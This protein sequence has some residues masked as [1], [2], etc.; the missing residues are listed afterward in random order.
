MDLEQVRGWA[1][2]AGA[3]AMRYYNAVEVRRKLDR[4]PVTAAD[5]EIEALL[6]AR[7][8]AAYPTHGVLGEEQ[9]LHAIDAEYVWVIDPI[10]GTGSF[11]DG[12][13]LWGISI[14]LLHRARP[15]LGSFYMPA[16]DEWYE[17]DRS[18]PALFNGTP[19]TVKRDDLLDSEA[20]LAVPSNMHR[21]Y[22]I[23][24]PGKVRSIGSTAAAICY[25]AR[26]SAAGALVGWPKLWDIAAGLVLLERAGGAA[27]L[28]RSQQPLDIRT[29]LRGEYPAEP[30]IV[31]SPEALELMAERIQVL[32]PDVQ[33]D[34]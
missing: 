8:A 3:I 13:P 21:R 33:N 11:V 32:R 23:D 15:V 24:Y 34:R 17:A 28:L 1:R 25:V 18:G 7:I 29:M 12:L 10:D 14:G 19:T 26:G 27:W 22:R 30:V 9:G 2:E 31:G 16:L 6:R 20:Y 4:S 5:E